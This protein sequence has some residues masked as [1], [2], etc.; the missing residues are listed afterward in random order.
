[1]PFLLTQP[2]QV[3]L[4]ISPET[5]T[6]AWQQSHPPDITEHIAG[7]LRTVYLNQLCLQTLLPWLQ[8]EIDVQATV[9]LPTTD[10]PDVGS[11]GAW[12]LMTG[13]AI[14]LQGQ[15]WVFLPSESLGQDELLIPQEWVDLPSWQGD[16]YFAVRVNLAEQGLEVWGYTTHKQLKAEA[17]YDPAERLYC[18]EAASLGQ[19]FAVLETVRE[20]DLEGETRLTSPSIEGSLLSPLLEVQVKNLIQRFANPNI[21]FP[22]LSI[23]FA[24]WGAL[25]ENET[26][27]EQLYSQRWA[28]L[29]GAEQETKSVNDL[30]QWF[31]GIFARQWF[32]VAAGIRGAEARPR[33]SEEVQSTDIRQAKLIRFGPGVSEQAF[34]LELLIHSEEDA[35]IAIKAKLAPS[36]GQTVLPEDVSLTLLSTDGQI[37]QSVVSRESDDLIQL[38]RFFCPQDYE[39][40][41]EVKIGD[42]AISESF[43]NKA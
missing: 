7:T 21:A 5:Q 10:S 2:T 39:F 31:Q 19:D 23:P 8:T 36:E 25:L 11:P 6:M 24:Q 1:M 37:L 14:A 9:V 16:Y 27:R 30:V 40:K 38:P 4:D 35:S 22:R 28:A 26:W 15:N 42:Q 43:R 32:P 34:R 3:W 33:S 18:L 12:E 29:T 41:L 20:L 17:E 13:A